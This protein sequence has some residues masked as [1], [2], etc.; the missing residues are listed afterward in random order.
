MTGVLIRRLVTHAHPGNDQM[1]TQENCHLLA[2]DSEPQKKPT[3][4]IP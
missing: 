2:K 4:T 1:K 3:L